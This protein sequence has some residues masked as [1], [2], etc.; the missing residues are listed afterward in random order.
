M[1]ILLTLI[2]MATVTLTVAQPIFPCNGD[3][4]FT[5]QFAPGPNT[6]ISQVTFSPSGNLAITDPGTISPASNTNASVQYNGYVWTQA[7]GAP[8]FTLLRVASDYTTTAFT[9][10]GMPATTNFNNAGVDKNG[11]MYILSNSNPVNLY[12]INLSSGTPVFVNT[13][14]V[15]GLPS[16]TDAVVWGDITIDPTTNRVYCWYHPNPAPTSNIVGLYEITNIAT[17]PVLIKIGVAQP[18]TLGSLFFNDRGELFGYGS[19][20]LGATQDRIFSIN[21]ATGAISQAGLPTTPVSQSDGCE[22]NFRVSLD[23]EVSVPVM[24]IPKCG[25][26]S[27]SYTFTIRNYTVSSIASLTFS[28]T[29]DSRLSYLTQTGSFQT[30]LRAI[31]GASATVTISSINGGINNVI[32]VTGLT[33]PLNA[34]SFKM[35]VKVDANLFSTPAV[36]QAQ[37][38]LRGINPILGGPN[39]PSNFPTT[40]A[41]KD[42]TPISINF[43]GSKCLPPLVN[44]FINTPIPQGSSPKLIPALIGADPDG[45]IASY[46]ILSLPPA[47]QGVLSI[48]CPPTPTGAICTGGYADLT[49]AVL[50]ANPGGIQL[51]PLQATL[52]RFR[53]AANFIGTATFN[54]NAV[55]NTNNVSSNATY[56]LPVIALPPVAN[57]IMENSIINTSPAV[58]IQQLS[59]SDIDGTISN[60]QVLTLPTTV[61]GVLSVPCPPNFVGGTCAAGFT[62]LTA[63]MLAN[64]PAGIPLTATQNAGL[65]F[66]P[67]AGF[68]GNAVFNYNATDNA[69]N[70]SNT[71]N[72][73]IPVSSTI[74]VI[75]PP[76]A[77][78]IYGQ[79]LNNSLS[80]TAIPSLS[81]SDLD[82]TVVSYRITSLPPASQGLL[83]ISCP[84]TPAG[85]ICTGGFVNLTAAVLIA[86]PTGIVLT[87]AQSASLRFDPDPAFVG[88]VSF[89]Y[90]ATDNSSLVSNPATYRFAVNN[91]PPTTININT[92]V[93]FASPVTGIL[94][95]I[96]SDADG[97]IIS[98]SLSSVPTAAQGVLSVP[99]P[100][101][102]TSATCTGGFA[103]L[104]PAVLAANP[105]GIALT[106]AQAAGIRFEVNASFSGILSFNYT[107]T[108]NNG[109]VST[110]SIYTITVNNRAP[111]STDITVAVIPNTAPITALTGL[112]ATDVDGTISSYTITSL[113]PSTSGVLTLNGVPVVAG[114]VLTPA[115]SSQLSFTP[116]A[117]YTGLVGFQYYATDNNGNISN[118]ANYNIPIS[119]VGNLPPVANNIFINPIPNTNG[120]TSIAPLS[121]T[122]PDGTVAS[123]LIQT[124]PTANQGVLSMACPP[125]P[126]GGVCTGG[127]VNLTEAVLAANPLGISLT[128]TQISTLRFAP[129]LGYG[130]VASFAYS[131]IDNSGA[132]SNMA[133]YII[134]VTGFSPVANPIVA[135]VMPLTNGPTAIPNL[136]GSDVDGTIVSYTI[137]RVPAAQKGTLSVPCPPTPLGGTCTGGFVNLTEAVLAANVAGINITPTQMAGLRFDPSGDYVGNTIF[138]YHVTDNAG[139]TSNTASYIIPISG[140]PPV[141]KNVL[142]PKLLNSS[143]TTPIPALNATDADGTILNYVITSVPPV[144]QGLL[145]IPCPATPTG[146]TCTG[147]FAL[148]T[149]AVLAANPGGI[150]LTPSQSTGLVFRP[151]S[152]YNGDVIFNYAAYDNTGALSNAATYTIPVGSVSV[153]PVNKLL[154]TASRNGN[155]IATRWEAELEVNLK[156]Y[157]LQYS[158]NGIDFETHVAVSAKNTDLAKYVSTLVNFTAPVYYLRLKVLDNDYSFVYSNIVIVQNNKVSEIAIFPTPAKQFV[159]VQINNAV[160]GNYKLRVIDAAGKLIKEVS[161]PNV[162]SSQLI[163]INRGT[164]ANG[165][166]FLEIINV[167]TMEKE[168]RKIIFN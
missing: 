57:N 108:D 141:S 166:F 46:N 105:G 156:H 146:A 132:T 101:T 25:T 18:Y 110:A 13:R 3:F 48:A 1:R 56:S 139:L 107:G 88:A 28:D 128:T 123:Y 130:G 154:F 81:A 85:G 44:N 159:Q 62:D 127:F 100:P 36:I 27:F 40:F 116:T 122:D 90:N 111:R 9:V 137:D 168:V 30:E 118:S 97:T 80:A 96:G 55:D 86:N 165:I 103:N 2:F 149:S 6:Y 37:A 21:K 113:P 35:R 77:E 155:N 121:G 145:S 152:T 42:G 74:T 47:S 38:Y 94:P 99:C 138:N 64:Y 120:I 143:N 147:G 71:A 136:I 65:R 140:V 164:M 45:A 20:N 106:P 39:E 82:G 92:S 5:R 67:A 41:S 68:V 70:L 162:I 4:L 22:C 135:P 160:A 144:S 19:A 24:E 89:A 79:T 161:A 52:I 75:R 104:T 126:A 153:L 129:T 33:V 32:N 11:L 15:T 54:F 148:L 60:Y 59:A 83:S 78:N 91:T 43:N 131:N 109:N 58:A 115:Q 14:A 76:L 61:Q 23:R 72:Y 158:T 84:A 31:Y 10:A 157:E 119:G 51:T 112:V 53:P 29:L 98:Y 102:P 66:R 63:A 124:V 17:T 114:Q 16:A 73:T 142:A 133:N 125:T 12:T 7:W 134:P 49:A 69:G 8:V 87:P 167:S 163:R 151:N 117:N 93:P 50:A 34:T 150:S 95:L 26:D